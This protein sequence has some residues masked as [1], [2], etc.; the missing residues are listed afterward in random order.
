[1]GRIRQYRLDMAMML[2]FNS[3]ERTLEESI[4]MGAKAGLSFVKLW[5][6][7]DTSLLEFCLA[8]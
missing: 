2:L 7:G 3:K 1:M 5:Y 6:V 8:L 4:E